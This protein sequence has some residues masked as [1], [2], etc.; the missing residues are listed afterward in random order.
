MF[1]TGETD[2]YPDWSLPLLVRRMLWQQY[3]I[4]FKDLEFGD[5]LQALRLHTMERQRESYLNR[6]H[7]RGLG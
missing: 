4:P 2:E 7:S 3:G 5:I 6:E 1:V